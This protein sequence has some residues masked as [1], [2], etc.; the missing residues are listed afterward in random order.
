MVL[1][2]WSVA[3]MIAVI[4]VF[5]ALALVVVAHFDG[6]ELVP[7]FL[8]SQSFPSPFFSLVFCAY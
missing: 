1:L 6:V 7:A 8:Q 5:L 4:V 3:V 2:D